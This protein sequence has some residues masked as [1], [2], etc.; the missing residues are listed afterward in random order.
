MSESD[1]GSDDIE[2]SPSTDSLDTLI[3]LA[4]SAGRDTAVST[5]SSS[6]GLPV[7]SDNPLPSSDSSESRAVTPRPTESG[8]AQNGRQGSGEQPAPTS[9]EHTEA[10]AAA[11][12]AATTGPGGKSA[13]PTTELLKMLHNMQ[14][15]QQQQQQQQQFQQQQQ[16]ML[17]MLMRQLLPGGQRAGPG[18]TGDLPPSTSPQCPPQ[19]PHHKSGPG[20]PSPSSSASPMRAM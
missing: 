15:S 4:T 1:S 7:S 16:E 11:A 17:A 14:L 10:T 13:N 9:G 3:G 2:V 6:A 8:R 12:S 19:P 18:D 5:T 20:T